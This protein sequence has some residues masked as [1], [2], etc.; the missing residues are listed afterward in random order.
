M[1]L[2]HHLKLKADFDV[3]CTFE[4]YMCSNSQLQCSPV[5]SSAPL[6]EVTEDAEDMMIMQVTLFPLLLSIK[7]ILVS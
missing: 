4:E 3:D 7:L 2:F 1:N 5:L 6:G